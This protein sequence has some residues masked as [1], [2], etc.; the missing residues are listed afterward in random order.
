MKI[1]KQQS[2]NALSSKKQQ[3][4]TLLEIFIALAI[5]LI[6]FAGVMSVFVGLRTTTSETSSYGEMQENGRFAISVLSNDLLR[7]GFWGDLP[8][9]MDAAVLA[10]PAPVAAN[11]CVGAGANNGSFPQVVG[12]FRTIW[13]TTLAAANALNCITDAVVGSDIIQIKRVISNSLGAVPQP[14]TAPVTPPLTAADLNNNRFYLIS[15]ISA[16]EIFTGNAAIPNI[17]NSR[18]WEYQHHI[19]YVRNENQGANTVPVLMQGRLLN[20]GANAISFNPFIDGIEMIR[21]WYGVDTDAD[22]DVNDYDTT[23]GPGS[24]LGDG[25]VDAFIPARNMTQALWDNNGSRILA[26]RIFV[27]VRDILPDNRYTNN[28]TYQLGGTTAADQF[29]AGGDNFRRLLFSSTV[30]LQNSKVK[31]WN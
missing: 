30:S 25:I 1:I 4:F 31:V 11:D 23:A 7:Q 2:S 21:F 19:Y 24:G 13:G 14:I 26:V 18:V 9:A 17:Q 5:G 27:L 8:V 28:N 12:H 22:A 20:G 15:N 6:L 3:G 10:N 29:N 16:A